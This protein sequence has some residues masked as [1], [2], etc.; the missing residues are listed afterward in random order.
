MTS[1]RGSVEL[2]LGPMFSGKTTELLRR[3][4]R[5]LFAGR[6]CVVVNHARDVRCVETDVVAT[7]DHQTFHALVKSALLPALDELLAF[8]VVGID[9]GQFFPDLDIFADLAANQGKIVIVAALDGNHKR[10]PFGKISQLI[11]LV[12]SVVKLSAICQCCGSEAAFSRCFSDNGEE[13]QVGAGDKYAALCRRC[14]NAG[15]WSAEPTSR[16]R[17]AAAPRDRASK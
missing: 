16:G 1:P 4:R 9:E 6:S 12:E 14:Y 7:H 11:P 5:H 2:I 10:Q 13:I 8:G 15:C 17:C 3:I